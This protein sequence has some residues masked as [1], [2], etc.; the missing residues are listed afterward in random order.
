[1][2]TIRPTHHCFDDALE[3]LS[4]RLVADLA[5]EPSLRLVHGILLCPGAG[6][7]LDADQPFAHAWVEEVTADRG[8]IVWQAGVLE[9]GQKVVFAVAREEFRAAMRVQASTAYTCREACAENAR[10]GMY[11]PW[12]PEYQALCRRRA[13]A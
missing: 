9:D 4:A 1:M 10:T 5:I 2:T 13:P 7:G 8:V 6:V 12:R 11:G 3:Y